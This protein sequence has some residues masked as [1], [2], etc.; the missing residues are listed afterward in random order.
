MADNLA[1]GGSGAVL[2]K[3]VQLHRQVRVK[4]ALPEDHVQIH[5]M[6]MSEALSTPFEME[7]DLY[8]DDPAIDPNVILG[9]NVTVGLDRNV[10]GERYFN[11]YFRSFGLHG[12][13]ERKYIYRGIAVPWFWFLTI[14]ENCRI[15]HEMTV[16]EIA[17]QIFDDH[18]FGDF[19]FDLQGSPPVYE[20]CVQYRESD[21]N[22]ISRLFEKEGLYYYFEHENG[23]HEMVIVDDI[24]SHPTE[25]GYERIEFKV[26]DDVLSRRRENVHSWR[27]SQNILPTKYVHQ[28]YDFK[29][30]RAD[31]T[32][33]GAIARQHGVSNMEVYQYP[34]EYYETGVGENYAQLRIEERQTPFQVAQ[35]D[36][37]ARGLK[38]GHRFEL[39]SHPVDEYNQEYLIISAHHEVV[40]DDFYT[41]A[42]DNEDTYHCSFTAIP[43]TSVYR[44]PRVTPK[45]HITG[46]QTAVVKNDTPGEEIEPD[47][48]GRVKVMFEWEREGT[49]SCWVRVSQTWAGA[50]WGGMSIP[51]DGQEVV[52]EFIDGNPD[53]PLITGR[54]YNAKSEHPYAPQQKPTVT[55]FKT[56]SSKG[57]GGFNELRFDDLKGEE[58]IFVHAEKTMDV[59]VKDVRKD[60]VGASHHEIVGGSSFHST[61]EDRHI[62]VGG[63]YRLQSGDN[64]SLISDADA[65]QKTG[66]NHVVTAGMAYHV[67]AGMSAVIEA[68]IS[69]T[70]KVGGNFINIGPGGIF[71]KGTMV[72]LNSGGAAG[73]G[74]GDGSQAPEAPAAA[75]DDQ[76]GEIS[77]K[78]RDRFHVPTPTELDNHPVAVSL[79]NAAKNGAVACKVCAQMAGQS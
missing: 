24:R 71:I 70:L 78:A 56:N 38:N 4:T 47:E 61:G 63:E 6:R 23:R 77:E 67:D 79:I 49:P 68:G 53:R 69:I 35:A 50:G 34:G 7:I 64:M 3:M 60:Y 62:G 19:R 32:T 17:S 29:K 15:F 39:F 54:V 44:P 9:H 43:M 45:P 58:N 72:M 73:S 27:Q 48:F 2:S 1:G 31:L 26:P 74:P 21:Y 18:G 59:R 75:L 46:P 42:S 30:P 20:Y 51:R 57:G 13:R 11:G 33:Q 55:T 10:N 52:V 12:S 66:M 36:G 14:T 76:A 41:S 5:T 16:V 40:S 28:D 65:H 37:N 8:S 22:F 25:S